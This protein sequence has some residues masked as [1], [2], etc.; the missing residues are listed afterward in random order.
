MSEPF[1][2]Q[3]A[4]GGK[5]NSLGLAEHVVQAVLQDK[6]R[7]DELYNCLF[8][9]D[10]WLRMRAADALEKVCRVHPE[11]FESYAD[12]LLGEMGAS[13]QASLQWHVAQMLGEITL[14]PAQQKQAV[15]WLEARLNDANVDWIVAANSMTTLVQLTR[16]GYVPKAEAAALIKKQ[17][18][19][20]STAVR[21][22]AAKLLAELVDNAT[23]K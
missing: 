17:E 11:W 10:P 12:R 3:L 18:G 9:S 5:T 13:P 16:A 22:R 14:T 2:H 8:E 15:G 6:S 1:A 4:V 19:H 21:R 23:A 7:L 20:R